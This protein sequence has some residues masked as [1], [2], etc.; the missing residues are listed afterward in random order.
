MKIL[1]LG[2]KTPE[3]NETKIK[4]ELSLVDTLQSLMLMHAIVGTTISA[5]LVV[6]EESL[7]LILPS[8][9]LLRWKKIEQKEDGC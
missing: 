5:G 4:N 3:I 7:P 6:E 9:L 8:L 1:K 2:S